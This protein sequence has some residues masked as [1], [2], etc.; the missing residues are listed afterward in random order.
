MAD[1]D[2][3]SVPPSREATG[4]EGAAHLG[5]EARH[6]IRDHASPEG[7]VTI[8]F[9]DIVDST[10]FRQRLGDNAAQ[11]RFR[12]HNQVVREQIGKHAGIV[13]KTQGDGFM[14]AFSDVV[15][16]LACT[17][18]IQ[19]AI[20]E[21]NQNHPG[22]EL[23]VRMGLNCGQA[24]REEEDFFGGAVIV[25]A[26]ISA[27]AKGG[28]ILVSE[29]VR[30]LAGLTQGIGYVRQ[31]RRRLKGLDGSYDIWSVPWGG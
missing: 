30:V 5:D 27:L 16:A 20:A 1:N 9:S 14:V 6:A 11:E 17:V 2:G 29:A 31:G 25:A 3:E 18:D 8:L 26:R 23:V 13:V 15:A 4:K 19:Q 22:E 10:R 24:I 7:I 28:Q 21:D 12:Q